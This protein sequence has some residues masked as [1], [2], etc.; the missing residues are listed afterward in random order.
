MVTTNSATANIVVVLSPEGQTS[1]RSRDLKQVRRGN[2]I[3]FMGR[4]IVGRSN[5]DGQRPVG[6]ESDMPVLEAMTSISKRPESFEGNSTTF[7]MSLN[8]TLREDRHSHPC[9]DCGVYYQLPS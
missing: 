1:T 3:I 6:S 7:G 4:R 2:H 9:K 5:T 8:V